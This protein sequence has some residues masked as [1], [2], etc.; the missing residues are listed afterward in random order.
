MG[1]GRSD[2]VE[3][4]GELEDGRME[5]WRGVGRGNE[6]GNEDGRMGSRDD[7]S[8]CIDSPGAILMGH[9]ALA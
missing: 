4:V 7:H 2:Q 8:F 9:D 3:P 6:R 5:P 1:W